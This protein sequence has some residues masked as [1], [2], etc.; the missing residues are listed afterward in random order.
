MWVCLQ[1]F[2]AE[3]TMEVDRKIGETLYWFDLSLTHCE[4]HSLL[5][6]PRVQSGPFQRVSDY[7][8]RHRILKGWLIMGTQKKQQSWDQFEHLNTAGMKTSQWI[9]CKGYKPKMSKCQLKGPTAAVRITQCCV[10]VSFCKLDSFN[11]NV[12]GI[13]KKLQIEGLC[14]SCQWLMVCVSASCVSFNLE[15]LHFACSLCSF[16]N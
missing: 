11:E 15:M 4:W 3:K 7:G 14:W 10:F 8:H 16:F 1:A 2:R 6:A 12:R 9:T 13:W 5:M